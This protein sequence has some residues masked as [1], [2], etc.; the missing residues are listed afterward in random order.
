MYFPFITGKNFAFRILIELLGALWIWAALKFPRFRPRPSLIAWAIIAFTVVLGFATIFGLSP[1]KSFWSNY[2]R[3]EGYITILHLLLYFLLLTSIFTTERDW[4]A[5]F[6]TSLAVSVIISLYG[7]FQIAGRFPIHQGG[8]RVDGTL[9]N[10]TY[11]AAY[12]LF[13]LFFLIWFFLR[14]QNRYAR[15]SYGAIFILEAVIL[16][17]TATRG[18]ILG[19]LGGL[20]VLGALLVASA[21]GRMRRFALAG[22]GTVLAIPIL[23]FLVKDTTFI[24]QNFVLARFASIS[25]QEPTTQSRMIIWNIALQG[26]R[27]RPLLGWGQESFTYLFSKYYDPRLWRQ[28]PW[29]DRAHNIFLDYLVSGGLLGLAA[30]V[31]LYGAGGWLL[32]RSF[33][34]GVISGVTLSALGAILAAHAFQNIF[35]FDNLTSHLLFFAVLGFISSYSL[36]PQPEP[37]ASRRSPTLPAAPPADLAPAARWGLGLFLALALALALWFSIMKPIFAARAIIDALKVG[38]RQD[39]RGKV[40]AAIAEF[41][42][43]IGYRTFGTTEVREQS[44]QTANPLARDPSLADQDKQKFITFVIA[45]FE[46]QVRE[47]PFDMRA[48]AFLA[49]AYSLAGRP[50]D[51]ITAVNEALKVSSRR[52]QFYFVA[53]EAYLNA[54]QPAEAVRALETAYALAPEYDEAAH[55]LATALIIAGREVEAEALLEKRFGASVLPDQR[56]VQAYAQRQNFS[57]VAEIWEALV[58]SNPQNYVYRVSLGATYDRLGRVAEAIGEIEEAIRL[59]PQFKAQ[60]E[61]FINDLKAGK[62]RF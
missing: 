34:R 36:A 28:E 1:Y 49:S 26:W 53:A 52:Q 22:L 24:R 47:Q 39:P 54:G 11:L 25:L 42:R 29:F 61:Q 40:D 8:T 14:T 51:T 7:V 17:F 18:A 56:Y 23:F 58:R 15:L 21:G 48:K 5:F 16:Y 2:E 45:E 50:A 12:L 31:S 46:R 44:S 59:E 9:G 35:V 55:N 30:Y 43:G 37:T 57:R 38:A 41:R 62:V 32:I 4:S 3:M 13:H 33:R 19:V 27:E 10:A 6:H 60:G 20:V